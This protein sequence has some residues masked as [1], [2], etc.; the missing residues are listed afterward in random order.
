MAHENI[1]F[2]SAVIVVS[3]EPATL[4]GFYRDALGIPLLE[5]QHD[6]DAPHWGCTLGDLHFA[7]HSVSDFPEHPRAGVGSVKLALTIFD[8][9]AYLERLRDAGVAP[10]YPPKDLGWCKMSAVTDPDGNLVELTEL[11]DGW[12]EQLE[13]RK[14]EGQDVVAHHRARKS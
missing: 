7:I 1:R 9:E 13:K 14:N 11:G 10:L 6:D 5:E 2:L 4:A 8:L 12:F 3:E